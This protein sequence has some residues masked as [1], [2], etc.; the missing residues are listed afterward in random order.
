MS[1][2]W[3]NESINSSDEDEVNVRV[4]PDWH[5]YRDLIER[6]RL[7]RLDTCRDVRE[8][9]EK[10]CT[11]LRRDVSGYLRACNVGDDNALCRDAGLVSRYVHVSLINFSDTVS[12]G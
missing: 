4:H 12:A 7:Y 5:K 3:D 11:D 8:Y 10:Y 1:H 2:E 9:Y 6:R